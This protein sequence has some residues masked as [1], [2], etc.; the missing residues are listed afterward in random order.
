MTLSVQLQRDFAKISP[1]WAEL[2]QTY[3]FNTLMN[4]T[5]CKDNLCKIVDYNSENEDN[6]LSIMEG[7]C[8]ILGEAYDFD[9]TFN[10]Y[11]GCETCYEFSLAFAN[12]RKLIGKTIYSAG[13]EESF[14]K[15]I[16]GF[17]RHFK[18]SHKELFNK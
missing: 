7:S 14:E 8:C 5:F 18:R 2:Y 9:E 13:D 10:V 4:S 1:K 17:V 3:R 6:I 16:K 15:T 12:R 11:R